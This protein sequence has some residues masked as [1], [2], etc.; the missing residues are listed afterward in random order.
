MTTA[1]RE[2]DQ[3]KFQPP[4]STARQLWQLAGCDKAAYKAL[5]TEMLDT[6]HRVM[7]DSGADTPTEAL[8]MLGAN[9]ITPRMTATQI[10]QQLEILET[11]QDDFE[12]W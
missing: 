3:F 7:R 11:S 4:I 1:S 9:S 8:L 12:G 5:L 10:E 2:R 6:M